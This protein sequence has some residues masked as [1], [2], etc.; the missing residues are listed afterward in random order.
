MQQTLRHG[1]AADVFFSSQHGKKSE[2]LT[3]VMVERGI[4]LSR[5]YSLSTRQLFGS[6][7]SYCTPSKTAGQVAG[8]KFKRADVAI[9]VHERVVR[10]C[11]NKA[12]SVFCIT[13]V[14]REYRVTGPH[15]VS[16]MHSCAG[17]IAH[18]AHV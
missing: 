6:H 17:L 5:P 3:Y 9:R 12:K 11:N 16:T 10:R 15:L 13:L 18:I 8:E 2:T 1:R 4:L 7:L 14:A